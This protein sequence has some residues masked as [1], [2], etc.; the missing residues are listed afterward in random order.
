LG[1][2]R[3]TLRDDVAHALVRAV[4]RLVSTP[5]S[6]EGQSVGDERRQEWRR[7]TQE[8][9]RHISPTKVC[10]KYR[11]VFLC[12]LG[13]AG[14]GRYSD[15]TLP[16]PDA[17]GPRAP[18]LWEAA[19]APV[20]GRGPEAW[21]SVDVL[22]PSVIHFRGGYL[23]LYSGFDGKTWRTGAATSPDGIAWTKTGEALSPEGWERNWATNG[24]ALVEGGEILYW[25]AAGDPPRIALARSN[26]GARF[27]KQAEAV[28]LGPRGSFDERGVSDPYVIRR[29]DFFYLFYLGQ[30]RAA[31]Q[32]LGVAR[33]RDGV[34]WEKLRSNPVLELGA[35]GAFD[36]NGLGE[37]AVWS[38][39]GAYWMLYT[40]RDR[41]EHR[42]LGLARSTDGVHWE[43]E[44]T[45]TPIS[46]AEAWDL[47]VVC[48]PTV[49]LTPEGAV[50]VWFG[51]G[52]VA[53]PVENIHGQIG[54][55]MLRGR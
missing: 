3:T 46:G 28:L 37:P 22:N 42:R 18:F 23:N 53:Q 20:L 5:S 8:C 43:R 21:D 25:Y 15:F 9:V 47:Q 1:T 49:E 17:A 2:P 51:G 11:L 54:I 33:S 14:C 24:S 35:P 19:P 32:R 34:A 31:R 13:L 4:S 44:E 48:D 52:D 41:G 6:R 40:G 55:A 38:S 50:R 26:D 30:D 10:R 39:G 12:V 16:A 29:G 27:V 45:F 36:E 7:G